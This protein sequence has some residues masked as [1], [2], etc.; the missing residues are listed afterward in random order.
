MAWPTTTTTN[1][2]DSDADSVL[3]A[4]TEIYA[5]AVAVNDIIASR[6]AVDGIASL[7]G[8]GRVPAGQLPTTQTTT[9][10]FQPSSGRVTIQSLVNLNPQSVAELTGL[11]AQVGDVAY[12]SNGSAGSACLAV[13]TG[14]D[15]QQV[16]LGSAVSST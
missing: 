5:A 16:V 2:L 4:R 3:L 9:T 1:Y 13:Y 8:T 10:L 11:T 6:A 12:C 7:D 14:S 15:W